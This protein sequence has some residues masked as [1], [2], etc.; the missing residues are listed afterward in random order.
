VADT[1]LAVPVARSPIRPS[2]PVEVVNGWEVSGRRSSAPLRLTDCTPLAKVL[3][4][5]SEGDATAR[6][7]G[8]PFGRA[9]RDEHGMLAVGQAPEEWLLVGAVGSER[10]IVQRMDSTA[11]AERSGGGLVTVV[12]LITHGRAL[13]RL[14]GADAAKTFAKLCAIN[15]SDAVTPNGAAFRSS[16]ARIAVDVVRDDRSGER[17]YLLHCER[18]SGQY[19]W[20]AFMDAGAEFGIDPDGFRAEG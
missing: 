17:S 8:V 14:S 3:V 16:V 12:D 9:R 4:R 2:P 11:E 7:L 10:E 18:S 19:L 15:F 13:L 5:A 1:P 6:H 20:D